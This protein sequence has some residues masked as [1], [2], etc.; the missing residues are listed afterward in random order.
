MAIAIDTGVPFLRSP[1]AIP[2]YAQHDI[3]ICPPEAWQAELFDKLDASLVD[4]L[5][6]HNSSQII[7]FRPNIISAV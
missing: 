1:D 4:Y 3:R 7:S 2:A 6:V 5:N